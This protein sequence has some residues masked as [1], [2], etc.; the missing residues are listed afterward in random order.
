MNRTDV[1]VSGG[2]DTQRKGHMKTQGKV[3]VSKSR[4]ESYR[5]PILF[6]KPLNLGN[7]VM[8][9]KANIGTLVI[10]SRSLSTLY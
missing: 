6:F 5:K 2:R 8:Q 4:R 10:S 7:L 1:L 3:A 9:P